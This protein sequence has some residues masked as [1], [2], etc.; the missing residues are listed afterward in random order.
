MTGSD[1]IGKTALANAISA[2]LKIPLIAEDIE[3][4][5]VVKNMLDQT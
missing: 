4:V 5:I 3:P 2:T 1:G